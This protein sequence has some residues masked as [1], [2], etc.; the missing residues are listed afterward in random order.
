[1]AYSPLGSTGS[2]LMSADPVV[3]IAEKKGISP[4]TVL[5]SYHGTLLVPLLEHASHRTTHT[6]I[7]F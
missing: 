2:P 3:K 5:L 6:Y 4:T 7:L 1:M